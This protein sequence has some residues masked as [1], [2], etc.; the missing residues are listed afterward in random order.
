MKAITLI[1]ATTSYQLGH[2]KVGAVSRGGV[3]LIPRDGDPIGCTDIITA[4]AALNMSTF[5]TSRLIDGVEKPCLF[6]GDQYEPVSE[7]Q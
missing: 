7:E 5:F 4:A 1:E 3:C 2:V 6:V